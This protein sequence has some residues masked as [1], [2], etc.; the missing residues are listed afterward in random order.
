MQNRGR[1]WVVGDCLA[2]GGQLGD[3]SSDIVRARDACDTT[4]FDEWK[5]VEKDSP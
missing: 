4:G 5:R 2:G 3:G 1:C